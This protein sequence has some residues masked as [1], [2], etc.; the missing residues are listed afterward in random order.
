MT[1]FELLMECE[2]GKRD[3]EVENL[4]YFFQNPDNFPVDVLQEFQ[5]GEILNY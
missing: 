2:E 4:K 5:N 3:D 1:A